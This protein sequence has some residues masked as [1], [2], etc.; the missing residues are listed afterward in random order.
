MLITLMLD[1]SSL[2]STQSSVS[3]F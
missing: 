2:V 1:D 3:W